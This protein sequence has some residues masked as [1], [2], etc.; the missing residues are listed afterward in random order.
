MPESQQPQDGIKLVLQEILTNPDASVLDVGAGEGKWGKLLKGK[1]NQIDGVEVWTPY[2]EKY[3]LASLYDN[4]HNINMLDINYDVKYDIMILGDVLEHLKFED[5]IK[6]IEEAK[7]HITKIYLIIPISLCVQDG[8]YFGN[9]FETHLYQWK[10]EEL[11]TL[12]D[13]KLIHEGYNPN[14]LVKIGTYIW[15]KNK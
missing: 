15:N 13:F 1:V 14:G 8:S 6:F 5:A 7:K 2:I 12:F 4:L 9:P 10:D 3:N 11:T